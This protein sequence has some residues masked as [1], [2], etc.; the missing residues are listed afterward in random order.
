MEDKKSVIAY[1]L[2]RPVRRNYQRR[3]VDIRALDETWQADLVDMIPYATV[4]KGN[5]YLLTGIDTFSKYA[6]AVPIESKSGS[7]VTRAMKSIFQQGRVPKN[8]HVDQS[9]EFYNKEFQELIKHKNINMYS[10]FSNLKASIC[11][12]FNQG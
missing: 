5:K 10:T 6:W 9:K 3:H 7:D 12:R 11:E 1:E 4:N 2:H 8:L